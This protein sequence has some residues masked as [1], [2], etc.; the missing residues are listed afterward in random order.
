MGM[1]FQQFRIATRAGVA[2]ETVYAVY[3]NKGSLLEAV[4]RG[5]VLRDEEPERPATRSAPWSSQV[6]LTR[7]SG[8]PAPGQAN[9][10]P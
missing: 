2:P 10:P 8:K 1:S 3:S 9:L 4:V 7:L 6:R 5:A